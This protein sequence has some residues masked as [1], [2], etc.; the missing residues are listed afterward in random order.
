[1]SDVL[2][3]DNAT[4]ERVLTM[5]G[6]I[7]SQETALKGLLSGDAINRPRFDLYVPTGTPGAFYRSGNMEGAIA[8]TGIYAIRLKSD[9]ITWPR[10]EQ[11]RWTE[12]KFCVQPGTYCGLVLLFSSRDGEPLAIIN[13]GHIQH[14]RVGGG[15]GIGARYLARQDSRRVGMLGSGGMARV[16]LEAF[17]AV[18][19][20]TEAR[21]YSPNAAHREAFAAEMAAKLG[22]DVRASDHPEEAVAGA[23]L[24]ATCTDSMRPTLRAEWLEPGQ[25]VTN[26]GPSEISREVYER[27]D[28]R[29]KQGVSGWPAGIVELDRVVLGRGHSPVAIAA[30]GEEQL[31]ELPSGKEHELGYDMKLPTFTDYLRG[32]VAGRTSEDQIT[33]WHNIGN[34]GLQF[35]AVG[36]WVYE[37]VR[38]HGLGRTLPTEWFLQDIKN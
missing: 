22:I 21:V 29:I 15:A 7:E 5:E 27:F 14:M 11:G 13:D 24:V 30:G 6:C 20:V 34:H 8:S 31:A 1:V 9:V 2:L 26:V 23:D 25:H 4:V 18:R 3:I 16:Y 32:E 33:F 38:K 35:A 10:D 28:V 19:P 12:E 36:G 17:R 37:L